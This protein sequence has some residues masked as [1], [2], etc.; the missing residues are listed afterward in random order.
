[1]L[2]TK[3]FLF[4]V[5]NDNSDC[6]SGYVWSLEYSDGGLDYTEPSR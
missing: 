4:N 6:R 2:T 3:M 1:M 5:R